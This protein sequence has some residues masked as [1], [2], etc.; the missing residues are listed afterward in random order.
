MLTIFK[1][2]TKLEFQHFCFISRIIEVAFTVVIFKR[3]HAFLY[4]LYKYQNIY[5][6]LLYYRLYKTYLANK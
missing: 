6:A 1:L 3:F 4:I 2:S 5:Q